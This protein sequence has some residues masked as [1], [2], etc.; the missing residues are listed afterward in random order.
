METLDTPVNLPFNCPKCYMFGLM[1]VMVRSGFGE[2]SCGELIPF[3]VRPQDEGD[4]ERS[5]VTLEP[6]GPRR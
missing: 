1:R 3:L 5:P 4:P 2:C 6:I